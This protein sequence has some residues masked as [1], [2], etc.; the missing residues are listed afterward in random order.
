[1]RDLID[2]FRASGVDVLRC[3][4]LASASTSDLPSWVC[5]ALGAEVVP[6]VGTGSDRPAPLIG[7]RN[8]DRTVYYRPE[9]STDDRGV[10]A[11]KG[12]PMPESDLQSHLARLGVS[13]PRPDEPWPRSGL[14][15]LVFVE[16]KVPMALTGLEARREFR[17][18]L[19]VRRR[20][21][22]IRPDRPR[23][24]RPLRLWRWPE[25]S[26]EAFTRVVC[27]HLGTRAAESV[28]ASLTD[29]PHVYVYYYPDV[30]RR[31]VDGASSVDDPRETIR[32]WVALFAHFLAVGYVPAGT[33]SRGFGSCCGPQ[34]AV[35]D[36]GFVDLDSVVPLDEIASSDVASNLDYALRS[37]TR[38]V[39]ILLGVPDPKRRDSAR[40]SIVFQATCA[41]VREVVDGL[42]SRGVSVDPRVLSTLRAAGG[43]EQAADFLQARDA[44]DSRSG[45][46]ARNGRA[47]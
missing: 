46:R 19:D 30:P 3:E 14:E 31:V 29:G 26:A 41:A 36:G 27:A 6:V 23:L 38:S 40:A 25:E 7:L 35:I 1:M 8:H 15:H 18:A 17:C 28:R 32:R 44:S 4:P 43:I 11:F 20:I 34:N 10:L 22:Q 42:A 16:H 21:A 39:A 2:I 12:V 45:A 13:Q 33:E 24:P 47:E 37:L 9:R 5:D